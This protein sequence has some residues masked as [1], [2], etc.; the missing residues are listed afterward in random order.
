MGVINT[1][2]EKIL[3]GSPKEK[4]CKNCA[5]WKRHWS[6]DSNVCESISMKFN[7]D[8]VADDDSGIETWLETDPDFGCT[9]FL[10]K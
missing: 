2:G 1:P 8:Y 10:E 4:V 3:I 7:V 9:E 6:G 5:N